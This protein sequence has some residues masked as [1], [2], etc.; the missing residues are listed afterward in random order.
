M[1]AKKWKSQ[2]DRESFH[3][4]SGILFLLNDCI[5][6]KMTRF[7]GNFSPA[8][9]TVFILDHLTFFLPGM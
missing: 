7:L 4:M 5:L 8:N 2:E 1:K 3:R 6:I 9:N